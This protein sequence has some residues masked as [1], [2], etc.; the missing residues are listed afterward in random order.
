MKNKKNNAAFTFTF[1]VLTY[2]Q[3]N[4]IIEALESIKYHVQNF[5]KPEYQISL[6]VVDDASTDKTKK[7]VSKWIDKNKNLFDFIDFH[8]NS[9]NSGIVSGYCYAVKNIKT[10]YFKILAGDDVLSSN[11][12]FEYYNQLKSKDFHIGLTIT[13]QNNK[14]LLREWDLKRFIYYKNNLKTNKKLLKILY[15]HQCVSTPEIIHSKELLK[16]AEIDFIK[17]NFS[18]IEDYP[19]WYNIFSN[20]KNINLVYEIK[21]PV[22][23]RVHENSIFCSKPKQYFE[24]LIKIK[25]IMF[26]NACLITKLSILNEIAHYKKYKLISNKYLNLQTYILKLMDRKKYKKEFLIVKKKIDKC[27]LKEQK[28]Y[29]EIKDKVKDFSL[30]A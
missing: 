13:L 25:K 6:I 7:L 19:L 2:N 21:S 5:A 4:Y 23:Y 3:E 29:N 28:Y 9:K 14:V 15:S 8:I 11:N 20:C 27:L 18:F 16:Y 10:K 12:I 1:C 17:E 26:K 24:D 22:L 30:N